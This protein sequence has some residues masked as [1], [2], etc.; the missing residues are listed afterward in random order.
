M[1]LKSAVFLWL[2]WTLNFVLSVFFFTNNLPPFWISLFKV[3]FCVCIYSFKQFVL[4][5]A[6]DEAV[7][8]QKLRTVNQMKITGDVWEATLW[9]AAASNVF[10]AQSAASH[11]EVQAAR[12]LHWEATPFQSQ[13]KVEMDENSK[14]KDQKVR[15][16]RMKVLIS[17][18]HKN[19]RL[20]ASFMHESH[21]NQTNVQHSS[22]L[23][24]KCKTWL[25]LFDHM[26]LMW[27][28]KWREHLD[29]N[30]RDTTQK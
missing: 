22:R 15:T 7:S 18:Q 5:G 17:L 10:D 26:Q 21:I 1:N 12:H 23:Q 9:W 8:L 30:L 20:S 25:F 14:S 4:L 13:G 2:K 28:E 3:Q 11:P 6:S 19:T 24:Q 27:P 16:S 29:Y